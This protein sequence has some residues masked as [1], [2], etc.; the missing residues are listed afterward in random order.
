MIRRYG[1]REIALTMVEGLWVGGAGGGVEH[2]AG[3]KHKVLIGGYGD[4]DHAATGCRLQ[5]NLIRGNVSVARA[6]ATNG[7]FGVRMAF[8]GCSIVGIVAWGATS[9]C[10]GANERIKIAQRTLALNS[11]VLHDIIE[12]IDHEATIASM[13]RAGAVDDL[14]FGE[15]GQ[16]AA[17]EEIGA[18]K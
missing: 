15:I 16:L 10:T 17:L 4:G 12:R 2:A 8:A 11:F 18:L 9:E 13:A 5:R 3:I 6:S 7:L 1:G 14:L